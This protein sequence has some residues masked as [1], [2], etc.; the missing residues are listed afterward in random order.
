[1]S[2]NGTA[3]D[4]LMQSGNLIPVAPVAPLKEVG[5]TG[6][7]AWGGIVREDSNPEFSGVR[8]LNTLRRMS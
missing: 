5:S 8:W 4:A 2:T 3:S 6:L 1:M 7:K